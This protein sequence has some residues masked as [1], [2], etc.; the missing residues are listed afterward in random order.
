MAGFGFRFAGAER[1]ALANVDLDL[2]PGTCLLVLGPSGSGKSTLAMALAGL[3]GRD[4]PGTLVGSLAIGSGDRGL[5]FQ[6]ADRQL[7]ME[8]VEDD[9]AFGLE[10]RGWPLEAMRARV[11]DALVDVGLADRPRAVVATLSGGQRQRL[12]LA[13]ALAPGPA[14]LVLDEPTANLDPAAAAAFMARLAYLKQEASTTIVVVEHRVDD[15]WPLADR[16]LVLGRDGRPLAEGRPEEVVERDGARMIDEGVW[17]PRRMEPA[18]PVSAAPI[19]GP[20]GEQSSSAVLEV[21]GLGFAYVAGAPVLQG[22]DLAVRA[23]ERIAIV[24]ANGSGKSTL[25]RLLVGLLPPG[26]G[27]IEIDGLAPSRRPPAN[28]L[29]LAGLVFQDPEVGFLATTV[30]EEVRLGL[31][32]GAGTETRAARLMT[33]LG[34]PLETYG[35]RSPYRLSGGEQ[36]RLSLAP[37][38]LRE[39]RLLVLDEPTFAQDRAGV[40]TLVEILR[41]RAEAG[42]AIVAVSHDE[43]FVASFATRVL[44]LRGGR[45]LDRGAS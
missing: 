20:D 35:R 12:A 26:A 29:A 23:G 21:L 13:G 39:P 14:L 2:A 34:L 45:L 9:V 5:V 19:L 15:T 44:E 6:D 38:L 28:R 11:P 7:V 18:P 17:L 43:R 24:G 25:A 27:S 42:T 31:P 37:A 41:A 16:L 30:D 40:T 1:V 4:V 22:L 8:R 32:R 36:R 3:L 10:S 33:A